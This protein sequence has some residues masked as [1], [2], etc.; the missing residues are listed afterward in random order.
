MTKKRRMPR[1]RMLL[2][3]LALAFLMSAW[4]A[5]SLDTLSLDSSFTYVGR[6]ISGVGQLTDAPVTQSFTV[7]EDGLYAVEVMFSNFNESPETGMLYLSLSDD[8]GHVLAQQSYPVAELKNTSFITLAL[9]QAQTD[10]AGKTYVLSATSDCTEGKGVTLRMGKR[11]E[12]APAGVLTLQDGSTDT[13]NFLNMRTLHRQLSYGWE[14]CYTLLA[15]AACC[16]ACLPLTT[17]EE[18]HA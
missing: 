1:S 15:L 10:S 7:T 16:L 12:D 14:G 18:K 11:N 17:K 3:L 5:Y 9:D 13:E 8:E 2:I 6:H 4:A